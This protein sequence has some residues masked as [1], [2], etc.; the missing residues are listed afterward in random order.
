MKKI[1]HVLF[2]LILLAI[3]GV[4]GYRYAEYKKYEPLRND[5]E[6]IATADYTS[7]F[8]ST[9]PVDNYTEED[10]ATYREIYT[11]KSSYCIPD[12]ETLNQYFTLVTQNG[13]EISSI[14]L[15][16]RPDIVSAEDLLTLIDTWYG[17]PFEV[18]ISYPSLKYWQELDD[19]EYNTTM[20]AY[21]DF[22]NTLMPYYESDPWIQGN[23]SLYFYGGT[24]WLVS[25]PNNYES[26]FNVNA[27][28]AHSLSMY[29]DKNHNYYLTLDNYE[30]TL[31]NFEALVSKSRDAE[32]DDKE[33]P[34]TYPDL[35]KWDVVFFGDSITAFEETSSISG[36]F[37][38]LTGAHTYNC[39]QGGSSAS[40]NSE[41][42]SSL[43]IVIDHFIAK[44]TSS[45][46]EDTLI[47]QG[48]TDYSK[49]AKKKRQ[50]CFVID[51][52]MND[53]FEGYPVGDTDSYDV[54]TYTGALRTSIEKLQTEY[55]DAL[56]VLMTPNFTNYFGNGLEPQSEQ[57][58]TLPDYV[59]AM[60]NLSAMYD[61]PIYNTYTRLGIDSTNH[62]EY[63]VDGCHPNE[64]TR[65]RMAQ[66]LAKII[67]KATDKT[68]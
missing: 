53:F 66:D 36:A 23:L 31:E 47:Y 37:G 21:K 2:I 6:R 9:F 19:E 68:E 8:F 15:G 18:I 11:L 22:V 30:E 32:T 42:T 65:Y 12:M 24:E 49:N 54:N 58:G 64:Q 63:L 7:V 44:D 43:P 52:G 62:T 39:A 67:Q 10:F 46:T 3:I 1:I 28:I 4:G 33:A 17:V 29:S 48:I 40:C 35:S 20:A 61:L 27:G 45:Y 41:N 38:G 60:E 59:A 16:V 55:P 34:K 50:K 57:G 25:N 5:C 56:I 14:Y 51:F 13:R 26:D